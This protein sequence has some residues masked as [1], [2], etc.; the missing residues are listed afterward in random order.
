MQDGLTALIFAA[1][2]GLLEIVQELLTRGANID[3]QDKVTRGDGAGGGVGNGGCVHAWWVGCGLG[4][5]S[6]ADDLTIEL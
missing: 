5:G 6:H 3:H 2:K 1:N 4:L